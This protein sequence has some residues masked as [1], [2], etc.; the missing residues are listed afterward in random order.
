M[1][2]NLNLRRVTAALAAVTLAVAGWLVFTPS[3]P[4][5]AATCLTTADL[6]TAAVRGDTAT[7]HLVVNYAAGTAD[8]VTGV[9]LCQTMYGSGAQNAYWVNAHTFAGHGQALWPQSR[10]SFTPWQALATGAGHHVFRIPVVDNECGQTDVSIEDHPVSWP[11]VQLRPGTSQPR[12]RY[13]VPGSPGERVG[14]G[15][16]CFNRPTVVAHVTCPTCVPGQ[17]NGPARVDL[18]VTNRAVY[19]QIRLRP[20]LIRGTTVIHLPLVVVPAGQTVTIHVRA[21]D[22]DRYNLAWQV[23]YGVWT[24]LVRLI[25]DGTVLCPT[26]P[27]VVVTLGCDCSATVRGSVADRSL[28]R[29][30]H[31]VTVTVNGVAHRFRV[32]AHGTGTLPLVVPRGSTVVTTVQPLFGGGTVGGVIRAS[33]V[34]VS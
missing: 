11:S 18:T 12:T 10:Q 8:L 7:A 26:P 29:Y 3:G 20:D 13:F 16:G 24:P 6:H 22:G 5:G 14:N 32:A 31:D 15:R 21:L 30:A 28:D 25:P 4:A 17:P 9:A 1:N 33:S 2:Y 34:T 19:A 23:G 27:Q